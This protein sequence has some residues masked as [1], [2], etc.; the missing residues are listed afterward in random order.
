MYNKLTRD[1]DKPF[2]LDGVTRI[3]DTTVHKAVR[4]A[5]ANCI[6]NTDFYLLRG[7]VILK[8]SDRIVMQ[9]P[10]NIRTGKAQMLR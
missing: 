4:E 3:E 7:I 5:L 1:F 6:V 8:E 10:G 2:A 9:N